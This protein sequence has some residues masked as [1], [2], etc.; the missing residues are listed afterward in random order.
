MALIST[1]TPE[2]VLNPQLI[3]PQPLRPTRAIVRLALPVLGEQLLIMLV[4]FSETL[5][6]G[7]YLTSAHLAAIGQMAYVMWLLNNLYVAIDTGALAIV[8]RRIGAGDR[9]G[10]RHATNQAFVLGMV[11]AGAMTALGLTFVGPLVDLMGL[12]AQPSA[13]ATRYLRI[14]LPALPA[15]MLLSIGN[16][17]LRGAGD[18][19]PGLI[20][21]AVMNVVNLALSWS[22]VR[23]W[24]PLPSLGWDGVAIGAA[25]GYSVGGLLMGLLLLA[26][27]SGLHLR[28]RYMRPDRDLLRRILGIGL[29]ATLDV[30]TIIGCQF[31]FKWIVNQLGSLAAAAHGVAITIESLGY[32]PGTAFQVAASTLAGQHLGAGDRRLARHSVLT[33]CVAGCALMTAAGLVFFTAS[34]PLARLF[35]SSDQAAIATQTAALLRIVAVAMPALAIH[36]VLTGALRGSGDTR[37]PLVF[38]LVGMLAVRIP[39]AYLLTSTLGWGVAGAWYAMAADLYV[40]CILVTIRFAHGGWQRVGV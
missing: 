17:C 22:L 19:V 8:A 3:A 25:A 2:P 38:S 24:G 40:R 16:A 5:L 18:T 26:G 34:G 23:G 36:M 30:M 35:I 12:D 20:C 27:R 37:W 13:L 1:T 39:T 14:L 4:G 10:A 33:A 21:M 11:L 32:L 31:W 7:R 28:L 29:P 15:M 9:H 6:T